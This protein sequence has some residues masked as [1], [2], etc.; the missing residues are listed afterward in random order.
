MFITKR[1]YNRKQ[2]ELYDNLTQMVEN[3]IM[4]ARALYKMG[5]RIEELEERVSDWEDF[6][7]CDGEDECDYC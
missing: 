2:A 6:I 3:N 1:Y 7:T 4:M 5:N